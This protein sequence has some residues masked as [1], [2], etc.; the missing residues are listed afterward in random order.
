MSE[1]SG[2]TAARRDDG[3]DPLAPFAVERTPEP[4]GLATLSP[5]GGVATTDGPDAQGLGGIP[6]QEPIASLPPLPEAEH[7]LPISSATGQPRRSLVMVAGVT[8]LYAA[9]VL[10]VVA[11]ADAWW[12][13]IHVKT[14]ATSTELVRLWHT[15]PGGWR[16]IVAAVL[17]CLMGAAMTAA[18]AIAGF[19]AWNGHRWSRI[20]AWFAVLVGLLG[21]LMGPWA[22]VTPVLSAVGAAIL[23][24]PPVGRYFSHWDR[25]RAGEP[26][27][28]R[29]AS[30]AS[31]G[32]LPRYR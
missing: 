16:S 21:L 10:S 32:P 15:R 28:L 13:T 7:G 22:W 1:Q 4:R 9:A 25:F 18:P 20:A 11:L 27:P 3:R 26:L 29:D 5:S 14:Y 24:L 19:N 6:G 2:A 30:R 17:M 8:L 23:L 31:Y 12:L